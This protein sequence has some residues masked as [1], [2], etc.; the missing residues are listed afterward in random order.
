M[1][2]TAVSRYHLII[3]RKINLSSASR[4]QKHDESS[5]YGYFDKPAVSERAIKTLLPSEIELSLFSFV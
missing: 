2:F 5:R 1:H 3:S 4:G